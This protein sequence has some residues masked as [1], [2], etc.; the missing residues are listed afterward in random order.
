MQNNSTKLQLILIIIS[1]IFLRFYQIDTQGFTDSDEF[2]SRFFINDYWKFHYLNQMSGSFWGRPTAFVL[3]IF[4]YNLFGIDPLIYLIRASIFGTL[5]I[6]IIYYLSKN[7]FDQHTAIFG[8]AIAASLFTFIFYS[9]SMKY[10]SLSHFFVSL[11]IFI[12][13]Y[14]AKKKEIDVNKKYHIF[15]GILCSLSITSHPNTIPIIICLI[16]LYFLRFIFFDKK[17]LIKIIKIFLISFSSIIIFYELCFILFRIL[18]SFSTKDISS[19]IQFVLFLPKEVTGAESTINFYLKFLFV[20]GKWFFYLS[21]FAS[22]FGIYLVAFKK[23]FEAFC[24]L[25]LAYIPMVIYTLFGIPGHVRNIYSSLIPIVILDAW[26]LSFLIKQIK[27][28][29]LFNSISI[30]ITVSILLTSVNHFSKISNG[31]GSFEKLY[32]LNNGSEHSAFYR[33]KNKALYHVE[34]YYFVNR[35]LHVSNWNEVWKNYFCNGADNLI[36]YSKEENNEIYEFKYDKYKNINNLNSDGTF[37]NVKYTKLDNILYYFNNKLFTHSSTKEILDIP[38]NNFNE[39]KREI[40]LEKFLNAKKIKINLNESDDFFT[41]KSDFTEL[42]D[43]QFLIVALGTK[44][45]PFLYDIKLIEN[46]KFVGLR[47]KYNNKFFKF[48]WNVDNINKDNLYFTIFAPKNLNNII[49]KNM[50]L[51]SFST[52]NK[53]NKIHDC[54]KLK[55]LRDFSNDYI[56]LN[57]SRELNKNI[58][59]KSGKNKLPA[60]DLKPNQEYKLSFKAKYGLFSLG[61]VSVILKP[62]YII[63]ETFYLP[64]PNP[65]YMSHEIKFTTPASLRSNDKIDFNFITQY[66][67]RSKFKDIILEESN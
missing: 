25:F 22:I 52:I 58:K 62:N 2:A 66:G 54:N 40:N 44:K 67:L 13:F 28:K 32:K 14:L 56:I 63:D 8:S 15:L 4:L 39:I 9:R 23:S 18:P 34:K 36:L 19:F 53:Y 41:I 60:T 29:Y 48:G 27:N 5:L 3:D 57:N 12:F 30:I 21:L 16:F 55:V 31:L 61:R 59:L 50:Y 38:I 42:N 43:D 45:N 26:F 65:F 33:D 1:A 20:Q 37:Y 6:L 10:I 11:C 46:D 64:L 7:Y 35:D 17:N 24:L 47:K 49:F 51:N